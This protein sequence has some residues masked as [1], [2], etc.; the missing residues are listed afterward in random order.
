MKLPLMFSFFFF[1][2]QFKY[3][4]WWP[5][6]GI[7]NAVSSVPP[8]PCRQQLGD[9]HDCSRNQQRHTGAKVRGDLV[10]GIS[11][12]RE[13][14]GVKQPAMGE[15]QQGSRGWSKSLWGG[16]TYLEILP[17]SGSQRGASWHSFPRGKRLVQTRTA[18]QGCISHIAVLVLDFWW[19][20]SL[21][22]GQAWTFPGKPWMAEL[23]LLHS[24]K[25]GSSESYHG[26]NFYFYFFLRLNSHSSVKI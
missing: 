12:V 21:S 14:A 18:I 7:P 24:W 26:Y 9:V 16:F 3:W 19:A 15:S 6:G 25:C 4:A 1:S 11:G 5:S 20:S 10:D 2:L 13:V 17:R 8:S 23:R 22:A